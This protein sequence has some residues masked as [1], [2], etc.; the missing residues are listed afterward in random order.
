MRFFIGEVDRDYNSYCG[1]EE[2]EFKTLEDAEAYCIQNKWSGYSYF[3]EGC[4][5]EGEYL[6][7]Y[8]YKQR[9]KG[10]Q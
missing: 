4:I 3:V 7:K 9:L 6:D 5:Y 10:V 1:S 8:R 2:K